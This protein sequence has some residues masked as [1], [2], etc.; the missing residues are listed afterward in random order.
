MRSCPELIPQYRDSMLE[1]LKNMKGMVRTCCFMSH[2]YDCFYRMGGGRDFCKED[3]HA[4]VIFKVWA[5]IFIVK[6]TCSGFLLPLN[7][8]L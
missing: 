3:S 8:E 1:V 6:K 4:I 7:H 2:N 5:S